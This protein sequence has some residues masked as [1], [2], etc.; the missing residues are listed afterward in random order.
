MRFI[1]A[2]DIHLGAQ[3]DRGM[4][5]AKDRAR[6]I[7]DGFDRLLEAV[8]AQG[9][10]FLLISGDLFHRE[11][12]KRELKEL[13]Y[14][15]EK[16]KPAKVVMIAGNHD[17]ISK[18]SY[19]RDFHWADNVYMFKRQTLECICFDSISTYIYGLSYEHYEI[20]EP[21]LERARIIGKEGCH[22]LLAHGGDEN[23]IPIAFNRLAQAGFHYAALGHIHKPEMMCGGR[24]A[25]SGALQPIDRNDTGEHG[26]I[27]GEWDGEKLNITFMPLEGRSYIHLPI[28]M[29]SGMTWGMAVDIV[30]AEMEK[31]GRQNI[32]K[33]IL[34]GR[35]D[36]DLDMDFQELLKLGYVVEVQDN[37]A[38]DYDYDLI[39]ARNADN[40]LGMYIR[41]IQDMEADEAIKNKALYYGIAA[42]SGTM[43]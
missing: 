1:H 28:R 8:R 38:P 10:D 6:E 22:I 33:I 21:L 18:G 13:N 12:L 36:P 31:R 19:Y 4:P 3:P 5:W 42:L 32:Y 27:L 16:L 39:Y 15:F 23:H 9:A 20:K 25:Y 2:A 29:D 43:R 24:A 17:Y 37:T 11:P 40:L 41:S 35:R 14:K 30:R 26:Y 34:N 7:W